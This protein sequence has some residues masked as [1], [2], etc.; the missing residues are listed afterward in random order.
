MFLKHFR[1][2][3]VKENINNVVQYSIKYYKYYKVVKMSELG[4][5]L[6]TYLDLNKQMAKC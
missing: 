3:L 5:Y 4:M 1:C 6:L 2:S